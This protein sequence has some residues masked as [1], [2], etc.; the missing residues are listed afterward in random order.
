MRIL[1]VSN[2]Y[3]SAGSPAFGT[4]VG[5]RVAAL[6][7]A[8]VE[9]ALAAITEPRVHRQRVVKYLRLAAATAWTAARVSRHGQ[10][11]V[12]EAHIA[13]PTGVLAYPAARALRAPL[14][15]YVHGADVL[16]LPGCGL[17]RWAARGLFRRAELVVANSRFMARQVAELEPAA[18]ARTVVVSPGIDLPLFTDRSAPGREERRQGIL[19]VGRLVPAKG[20]AVLLEALEVLRGRS[21]AVPSLSVVGDGPYLR[22]L[23]RRARA[24]GLDVVFAGQLAPPAVAG[25]MRRALVVVVPS[26]G[27]EPLGLAAVEA[28]AAGAVV[29]ASAVGG[30]T[31]TVEDGRN[32]YLVPAGCPHALAAGLVRALD[33]TGRPTEYARLRAAARATA[34]E[35]AADRAVRRSLGCYAER[36]P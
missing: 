31:E 20:P 23:E 24:L 25:A 27:P 19:F 9:V 33:V 3:P 6:R 28:M 5:T 17:R 8:G 7:G 32:G 1:L 30:L 29:V 4:F 11:D 36:W 15:L 21:G 35:H 12:V 13:Y 22:W 2:L 26:T 16:S 10:V 14:V 18:A 34:A